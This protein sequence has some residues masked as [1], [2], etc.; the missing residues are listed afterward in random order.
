M[1]SQL[2]AASSKR[3][4]K[5]DTQPFVAADGSPASWQ[6]DSHHGP[7]QTN[8]LGLQDLG[9][10]FQLPGEGVNEQRGE[11]KGDRLLL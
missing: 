10:A 9:V 2:N 11:R 5:N 6:C 7:P 8:T 4:P 3:P 1:R